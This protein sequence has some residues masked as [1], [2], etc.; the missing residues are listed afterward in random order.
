MACLWMKQLCLVS[1]AF[2]RP[3]D[4]FVV[5]WIFY[6][7]LIFHFLSFWFLVSALHGLSLILRAEV[8]GDTSSLLGVAGRDVA[9]AGSP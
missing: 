9:A 6:F 7:F 2:Q 3:F 4:L 5:S 8:L 1:L